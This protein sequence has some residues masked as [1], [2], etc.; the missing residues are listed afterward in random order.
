VVNC[1]PSGSFGVER[2]IDARV[3][4]AEGRLLCHHDRV[5]RHRYER[6]RTVSTS[7]DDHLEF[8]TIASKQ[9]GNAPRRESVTPASVEHERYLG[10]R[11]DEV[12]VMDEKIDDFGRDTS[13]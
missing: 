12:E 2:T 1:A 5:G 13:L 9:V 10:N 3:D 8:V 4:W 6:P 11:P 7:R